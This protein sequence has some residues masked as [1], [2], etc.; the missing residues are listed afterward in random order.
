MMVLIFMEDPQQQAVRNTIV[1]PAPVV[2][3][4]IATTEFFP[5][6]IPG[7]YYNIYIANSINATYTAYIPSNTSWTREIDNAAEGVFLLDYTSKFGTWVVSIGNGEA[8]PVIN[9]K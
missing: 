8:H 7:I 2:V 5:T 3:Q 6:S 9:G 1:I 4:N